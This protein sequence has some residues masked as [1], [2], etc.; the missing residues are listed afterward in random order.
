LG[1][2]WAPVE[3]ISADGRPAMREI[4]ARVARAELLNKK[5]GSYLVRFSA[6][7]SYLLIFAYIHLF[8]AQVSPDSESGETC[9]T[10]TVSR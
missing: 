4:H 7:W 5:N 9:A 6:I 1:A 10:R 8:V 3:A 2:G